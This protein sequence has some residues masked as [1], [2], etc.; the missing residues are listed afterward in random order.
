MIE[1]MTR[2]VLPQGK[3]VPAVVTFA[4]LGMMLCFMLGCAETTTPRN[5]GP[6]TVWHDYLFSYDPPETKPPAS[7]K[8]TLSIVSPFYPDGD[9]YLSRKYKKVSQGW[10]KSFSTD[11][12]KI[13]VAKGMTVMGNF[14]TLDL[15]TYP[16]KKN[17]NLTL[18][19]EFVIT[20]E[21]R[22]G[23]PFYKGGKIHTPV[24]VRLSGQVRLIMREPLSSEK[25]WIKSIPVDSLEEKGE[26]LSEAVYT[27]DGL[28]EGDVT[29]NGA[30][31]AVANMIKKLY[32]SMMDTVW[33]YLD[34]QEIK[35]LK[36][37]SEEVR[38]LKRY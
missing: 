16:D 18:S 6:T 2:R 29:Y 26:I 17:T 24:T 38:K 3:A 4:A 32:P 22:K 20:E 10:A 37:K 35:V 33:R 23:Q 8:I 15:M 21:T 13:I 36:E 7:V 34:V 9:A 5:D 19:P 11:L 25:I 31:D 27:R 28:M 14:D 12:D 30:E 1:R